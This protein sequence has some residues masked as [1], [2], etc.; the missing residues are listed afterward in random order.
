MLLSHPKFYSVVAEDSGVIIGS[1]FLDERSPVAGLGPITVSP[2]NQN[3]G[4]GSLLMRHMLD[5]AEERNYPGVR[6]L[7]AA[8][9]SRSLALYAGLNFDVREICCVVQGPPIEAQLDRCS[10]RPTTTADQVQ[11]DRLCTQVHGHDRR[12]EVSDCIQ[13]GNGLVVK[14]DGWITGYEKATAM[15]KR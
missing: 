13:Q 4:V 1:N 7:Q 14:R 12:G 15:S 8:Y 2:T 10:V 5:R 9:H 11:C 3:S 6:L